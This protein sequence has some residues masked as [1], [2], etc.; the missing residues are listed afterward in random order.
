MSPPPE[1][2]S[3]VEPFIVLKTEPA[4]VRFT[5]VLFPSAS[6]QKIRGPRLVVKVTAVVFTTL[7]LDFNTISAD[8]PV[9][10]MFEPIERSAVEPVAVK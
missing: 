8:E 6:A 5:P 9:A 2:L 7:A 3:L 10:V 4:E 1:A